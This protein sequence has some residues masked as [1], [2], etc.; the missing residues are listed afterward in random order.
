[1]ESTHNDPEMPAAEPAELAEPDLSWSELL[2]A[3][4]LGTKDRWSGLLLDRLG[5]WLTNARKTLFT[6]PA[7]ADS[8]DIAQQL[9]L[10]V[11]VIASRWQPQ[12]EDRWIPRRLVEAAAR[13]VRWKLQRE[14]ETL[15]DELDLELVGPPDTEPALVFDTPIG[16]ATASDLEVLYRYEVLGERLEAM[17]QQRGMT[18]GQMRYRLRAARKRA[19]A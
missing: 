17:A 1:M 3:Y 18:P 13:R 12:C 2:A 15:P 19:R 11:L 14:R 7:R 5:P 4:R 10:E 8:D 6:V 9:V 16:K